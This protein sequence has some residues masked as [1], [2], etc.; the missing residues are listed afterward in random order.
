MTVEDNKAL[1]RRYL[2]LYRTGDLR[3]ADEV[4]DSNFVDHSHLEPPPGPADVKRMVGSVH[5]AF[6]DTSFVVDDL[7]GE[8]DIVAFRFTLTGVHTGIFDGIPPT[9]KRFALTGMDFIRIA[10]SKLVELWSNQDT[11]SLLR[12]LGVVIQVSE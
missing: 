4:I 10:N 8:G 3:I 6:S 9:G 2:D 1:V 12:Q 11:L 7:I 5:S